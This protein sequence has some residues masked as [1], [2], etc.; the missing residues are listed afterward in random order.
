MP[1]LEVKVVIVELVG[2]V[3]LQHPFEIPGKLVRLRGLP[4][5]QNFHVVIR[6]TMAD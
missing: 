4:L 2:G 6:K 5:C 3:K 1:I